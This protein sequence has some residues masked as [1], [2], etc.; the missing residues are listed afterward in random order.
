MKLNV[1][2]VGTENTFTSYTLSADHGIVQG[3]WSTVKIKASELGLKAGDVI[4]CI[5]LSVEGTDKD[6]AVLLG[7][8]SFIPKLY[9]KLRLLRSLP[10]PM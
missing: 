4:G 7:E 1:S 6:Y 5:G 9:K 10:T 8:M 3:K 2:K